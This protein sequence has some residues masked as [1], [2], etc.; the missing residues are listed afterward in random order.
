MTIHTVKILKIREKEER[1]EKSDNLGQA[2][3]KCDWL[4][5]QTSQEFKHSHPWYELAS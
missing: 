3:K 5:P 1:K 2:L 4:H